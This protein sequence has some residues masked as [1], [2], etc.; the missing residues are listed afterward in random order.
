MHAQ[1]HPSED[2]SVHDAADFDAARESTRPI[3]ALNRGLEVLAEL[4]RLERA[5]INTLASA[6]GLP[7]TTTYRILETLRLGGY[8]ERDAH[9]DCYRPTIM[10]R[11]LSDGFDDEAMVAHIAK[12][13]IAALC[14]AIVWPVAIATPSGGAMMI[15]ETT[16]LQSPLALEQYGAGIRVPMLTSAA[17]R[18]YLAFCTAAQREA[19]LELLSRS[20]LPE[21]RLVRSRVDVEKILSETRSQGYAM[22]Q[23]ARR[24]SEETSLAIP[25]RVK[26]RVLATISVRFAATA[27]PLRTAIEQFLPKMREVVA[28][29]EEEFAALQTP[30]R[31]GQ[32][33]K[34]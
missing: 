13:H 25:V 32:S 33:F 26:D 1:V 8:V 16:D 6:V 28:K 24:V 7:R 34:A 22:A 9:D 29:I 11:S 31:D 17:G 18:A 27:V 12:P 2:T 4:N 10:V 14:A 30:S 20:S 21:D 5:A 15:R 3:R 23:R 19:L